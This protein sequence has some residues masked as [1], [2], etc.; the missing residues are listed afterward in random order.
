MGEVLPMNDDVKAAAEAEEAS[1]KGC[2]YDLYNRINALLPLFALTEIP[3][4]TEDGKPSMV[5]GTVKGVPKMVQEMQHVDLLPRDFLVMRCIAL[6]ENMKIL[7]LIE[8]GKLPAD[9][10]ATILAWTWVSEDTIA[11]E[12][13]LS[14]SSVARTMESCGP[15]KLAAVSPRRKIGTEQRSVGQGFIDIKVRGYGSNNNKLS[16]YRRINRD[17]LKMM[18]AYLPT[19]LR[20][21]AEKRSSDDLDNIA[22][23]KRQIRALFEEEGL[24]KLLEER[25]AER[26]S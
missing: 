24:E 11:A 18:E 16:Y 7:R 17:W 14:R 19:H 25:R 6:H 26:A 21:M 20:V 23:M 10:R 5:P 15:A 22:K 2:N 1:T 3:L 8:E 13:G 9:H 4:F 12:C